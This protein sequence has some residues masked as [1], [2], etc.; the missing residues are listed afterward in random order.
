[1]LCVSAIMKVDGAE[2]TKNHIVPIKLLA[3]P[4]WTLGG[5]RQ[6]PSFLKQYYCD[7]GWLILKKSLLIFVLPIFFILKKY[8]KTTILP[9]GM[10]VGAILMQLVIEGCPPYQ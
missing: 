1:M 6:Y 8:I 7:H 9:L 4:T 10:R 5:L 3:C 2:I